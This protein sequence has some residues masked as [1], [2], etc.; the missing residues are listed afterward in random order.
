MA[1]EIT[2]EE[3][4]IDLANAEAFY[5]LPNFRYR[6][7]EVDY[8]PAYGPGYGNFYKQELM[9]QQEYQGMSGNTKWEWVDYKF[10]EP[11]N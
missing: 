4:T 3:N 10:I 9:L 1:D 11:E 7:R 5:K 6:L 2:F 8:G